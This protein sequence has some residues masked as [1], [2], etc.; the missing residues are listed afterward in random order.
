MLNVI[1]HEGNTNQNHSELSP[2]IYQDVYYP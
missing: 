2:Y 1:N